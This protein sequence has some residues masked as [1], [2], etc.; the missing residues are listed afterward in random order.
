MQEFDH[1]LTLAFST[2]LVLYGTVAACGYYYWGWSA[3]EL[4]TSDLELNS[5]WSGVALAGSGLT[6]DRLVSGCI[7]VNA[8]TTYPSLLMVIQVEKIY[9]SPYISWPDMKMISSTSCSN[10]ASSKMIYSVNPVNGHFLNRK[11]CL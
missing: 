6:L 2:M 8:A 4:V 5:P 11:F 3:H 7:L 9:L 1:V 10:E